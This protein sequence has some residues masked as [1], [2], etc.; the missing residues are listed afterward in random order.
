[1]VRKVDE[2][3]KELRRRRARI[4]TND[5]TLN[6]P[7]LA[8][9]S[10]GNSTHTSGVWKVL[11]GDIMQAVSSVIAYWISYLISSLLGRRS[12]DYP[13]LYYLISEPPITLPSPSR[14]ITITRFTA[15]P[16]SPSGC[17]SWSSRRTYPPGAST[18]S[19]SPLVLPKQPRYQP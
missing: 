10:P 18:A 12:D 1:M 11:E 14:A 13:G 15:H 4:Y 2:M 7:R 5:D 16:S 19:S 6:T 3:V 8:L 9:A 17:A